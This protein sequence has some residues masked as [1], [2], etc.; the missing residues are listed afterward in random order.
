MLHYLSVDPKPSGEYVV[1]TKEEFEA[2]LEVIARAEAALTEASAAALDMR[3]QRLR[4]EQ[5]RRRER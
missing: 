4:L 1:L 2:L 3:M 5:K